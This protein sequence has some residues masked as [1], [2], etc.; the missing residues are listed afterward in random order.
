MNTTKSKHTIWCYLL[1]V[2]C[3]NFATMLSFLTIYLQHLRFSVAAISAFLFVYQLCKFIF[4]IP[5]GFLSDKYG[6]KVIGQIG[7]IGMIFYY[8]LLFWHPNIISMFFAL[9]VRGI[10]ESC[11]SGSL[12]SLFIDSLSKDELARYNAIERFCFY[13]ATGL[14][15]VL[16]GLLVNAQ[17]FHLS[18]VVDIVAASFALIFSNGIHAPNEPAFD[19]TS[20][21]SP[22]FIN[23]I[24]SLKASPV[25]FS[26]LAMD[27]AQAFCFIGLEEFYTLVLQQNG[28]DA[29][30][31]GGIIAV[32]LI[33]TSLFG[34]FAPTLL[35]GSSKIDMLFRFALMRLV[36]TAFLLIP[37]MPF[38][39]IPILYFLGDLLFTLFAPIK[40]ELFQSSCPAKYRATIIS[41]QSQLTSLGAIAF[42]LLSSILSNVL[43]I[44]LVLLTSLAVSSILYV[45]A[46]YNVTSHC[47]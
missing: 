29:V 41:M 15:A 2:I 39:L 44:Q 26:F 18:I 30:W 25:L 36:A 38:P 12:E 8:G 47:R 42:F 6:R 46:L 43:D 40:Y 3:T 23:A 33:A 35:K 11:I 28:F 5:T 27:F 14:S 13:A 4:E 9:A 1:F 37:G 31:S 22:T 32:Q 24:S 34:I 7:L 16:G 45:P 20:D 10:S 21:K 17:L 19:D